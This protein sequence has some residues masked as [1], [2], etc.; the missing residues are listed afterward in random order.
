M[1]VIA[2]HLLIKLADIGGFPAVSARKHGYR[3]VSCVVEAPDIARGAVP[4]EQAVFG[5][6]VSVKGGG[7]IGIPDSIVHRLAGNI[8]PSTVAA[9][10][11]TEPDKACTAVLYGRNNVCKLRII[12]YGGEMTAQCL[13]AGSSLLPCDVLDD[14]L[15]CRLG[16]GHR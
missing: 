13:A 8:I 2:R 5:G 16:G 1:S 14:D 10:A 6:A 7:L 9:A 4:H 12:S 15:I 11:R 3:V